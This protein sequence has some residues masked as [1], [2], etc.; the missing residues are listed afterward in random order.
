MPHLIP[1]DKLAEFCQGFADMLLANVGLEN[2][3]L[4]ALRARDQA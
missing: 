3:R 1:D 4:S 2:A